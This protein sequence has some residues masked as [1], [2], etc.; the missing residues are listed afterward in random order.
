MLPYAPLHHL[1]LAGLGRPLVMTSANIS[2]EPICY[3][4]R[5]ALSRLERIAD[6]FLMHD[7]R[8]HIRS[9][10][11]VAR[12]HAGRGMILRRSRGFAPAPIKTA[13]TS[14]EKFWRAEQS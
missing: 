5:D 11:S 6:Y 9:D 4:D 10:D 8:I 13:F 7:R 1:L 12:V 2:D 14:G 3:E